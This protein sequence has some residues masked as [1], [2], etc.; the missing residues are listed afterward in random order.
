MCF[1]LLPQCVVVH[2]IVP[3][4]ELF[5]RMHVRLIY[6][7]ILLTY[8]ILNSLHYPNVMPLTHSPTY[9]FTQS[10]N[11]SVHQSFRISRGHGRND[12]CKAHG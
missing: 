7:L 4:S 8:S 12:Y 2:Y 5:S 9:K 11:Q 1:K 6:A 3:W 10:I